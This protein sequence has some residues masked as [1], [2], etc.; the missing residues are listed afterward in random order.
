MMIIFYP[1]CFGSSMPSLSSEGGV[2]VLENM[3]PETQEIF[4][5][6]QWAGDV[7]SR[8]SRKFIGISYG[9]N[10]VDVR[11]K[12][13]GKILSKKILFEEGRTSKWTIEQ[14]PS[15]LSEIKKEETGSIT[16]KNRSGEPV[17]VTL[18]PEI[19]ES[20]WDGADKT[21][22]NIKSGSHSIEAKGSITG[23]SSSAVLTVNA[24]SEAIFF[25][26]PPKAG[27]RII[28]NSPDTL[29][30]SL[31]SIYGK[32]VKP[33]ESIIL[34]DFEPGI[35]EITAIGPRE[36]GKL[37]MTTELQ[38]SH[39]NEVTL[40]PP[41]GVLAVIN[42]TKNQVEVFY[43]NRKLGVVKPANAVNFS[44][45]NTGVATLYAAN[46][47]GAIIDR[48]D[49]TLD[50][51][52]PVLWEV[53]GK[54]RGP[55]LGDKPSLLVNNQTGE[56]LLI[57]I[58]DFEYGRVENHEQKTFPKIPEGVHSIRAVG[59][60]TG[61]IYGTELLFE[62]N[63][64][65]E[66]IAQPLTGKLIV[67][68]LKN[69]DVRIFVGGKYAATVSKK[70]SDNPGNSSDGNTNVS[71]ILVPSGYAKVEARGAETLDLSFAEFIIKPDNIYEFT[72]NDSACSVTVENSLSEIIEFS[73]DEK[74][75]G[76]YFPG[77]GVTIKSKE[78]CAGNLIAKSLKHDIN[79]IQ[80][81]DL[82]SGGKLLFRPGKN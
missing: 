59:E 26:P 5:H 35:Y 64:Q 58:D 69:E 15:S 8:E 4:I 14:Y 30:V 19:S 81:V 77:Q 68:N 28:N 10:A 33:Q 24:L 52:A 79:W 2:L 31:G 43:E 65:T 7:D 38:A 73:F 75:I 50:S 21:L 46:E 62:G 37:K 29:K 44:D 56:S 27:I 70:T 3:S 78:V 22:K 20:L 82:K 9:E 1:G 25:I 16:I 32:S 41:K 11:G 51:V 12:K 71:S 48:T 80:K 17:V 34:S 18:T 61:G 39:M 42:S 47:N 45:L 40:N 13:S 74:L 55:K 6:G 72:V 60:K 63:A 67:R 54:Y 66:W 57:R 23:F 36:R 53:K 76:R 49:I